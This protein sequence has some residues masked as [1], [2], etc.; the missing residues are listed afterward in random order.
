VRRTRPPSR[1]PPRPHPPRA[2]MAMA[3]TTASQRHRG[4]KGRPASVL[5]CTLG[6]SRRPLD[7]SL[8][9]T[10]APYQVGRCV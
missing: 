9:T 5:R 6:S 3:C 10:A 2:V 1:A 4:R 7:P 8:L